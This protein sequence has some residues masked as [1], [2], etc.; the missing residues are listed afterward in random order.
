MGAAKRNTADL[1]HAGTDWAHMLTEVQVCF[2]ANR[3]R[4]N[5]TGIASDRNSR[6]EEVKKQISATVNMQNVRFM[7]V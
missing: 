6:T 7:D 3:T 4:N 1:P 2:A 5:P